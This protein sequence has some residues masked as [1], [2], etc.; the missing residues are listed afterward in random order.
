MQGERPA[1]SMSDALAIA[2]RA[3]PRVLSSVL[4]S[5]GVIRLR[6]GDSAQATV[7]FERALAISRGVRDREAEMRILGY[8]AWCAFELGHHGEARAQ[9]E[10]ALE[11][12]PQF[13]GDPMES[14]FLGDLGLG[15]VK[16]GLSD[17]ASV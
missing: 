15:L 4:A 9:F 3:E 14:I 10:E 6:S 2:E 17:E 5:H 8:L 13:P 12:A 16:L 7:A 11:L 1:V